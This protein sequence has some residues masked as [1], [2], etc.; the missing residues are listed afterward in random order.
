MINSIPKL[1]L[2]S[3]HEG[4]YRKT[5]LEYII[6]IFRK[7]SN[8]IKLEKDPDWV[9]LYIESFLLQNSRIYDSLLKSL[10]NGIEK[11][12]HIPKDYL[13]NKFAKI[14]ENSLSYEYH[15]QRKIYRVAIAHSTNYLR[16]TVLDFGKVFPY[17]I[18]YRQTQSL[19]FCSSSKD[20]LEM[21]SLDITLCA[22]EIEKNLTSLIS[23]LNNTDNKLLEINNSE[24]IEENIFQFFD[25]DI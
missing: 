4:I 14:F 13:Y 7:I 22:N 9:Q 23:E 1:E 12:Y 19:I 2:L 11:Y 10:V 8:K 3:G 17:P 6:R 25:K 21:W 15:K 16:V 24:Q 18:N 20:L 5:D